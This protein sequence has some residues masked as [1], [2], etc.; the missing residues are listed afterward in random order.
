MSRRAGVAARR[1]VRAAGGVRLGRV[2]P[3]GRQ[4]PA[5]DDAAADDRPA[6]DG[7]ARRDAAADDDRAAAVTTTTTPLAD[8]PPCPV[9]ALDGVTAPVEITFWHAMTSENEKALIELTDA[10]NA[11]QPKVR[12][13]LE[14]QGG[15]KQTIDKYT[16]S[17]PGQ[18]AGHGDAAR[19]HGAADGRLGLGD[20]GRGVHRGQRASTRR[21][22]STGRCSR[23]QTEGVQWS[24][25][26]NVSEPVLFYNKTAFANAGLDPDDP[27]VSLEELR[28]TSQ[29]LVDAPG[30]GVGMAFDSGVDSG[31]GWFIE[32][33][34]ARAGEPYADNDNGRLGA[35]DAGAL[36]RAARRRP[37][38][39]GAVADHR[40]ARRHRR[41]QPERPGRAAQAG[42]PGSARRR[43]RSPRR[44]RSAPSRRCST[45]AS[46]R[47]S[48][49]SSS[50]SA[51]C[52]GPARCPSAIVGGASL[53]VVAEKGDDQ[54]AAVWDYMQFLTSAQSQSTWAAATG[55]VPVREDALD[56]RP[57][58]DDVRDRPPLQGRLRPARRPATTAR[59]RS[60][61]C[62]ARCS[63]CAPSP[64][65]PWPAI[66]G[67]ADVAST[68]AA[69]A[70]QSDALI[71]ELQRPQLTHH[72]G[73]NRSWAG[74]VPVCRDGSRPDQA[75]SEAAARC[76]RP[77]T[78]DGCGC[79]RRPGAGRRISWRYVKRT[80]DVA[81][82]GELG[83]AHPV[84][85]ELG[86]VAT[87]AVPAVALE[88]DR[89]ADEPEVDLVAR[90]GR[91][92][93]V[94]GG[95]P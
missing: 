68:L 91:R 84:A 93:T 79:A 69:A 83:V 4:R 7:G 8:L 86:P 46:S 44:R 5:A 21:R 85:L 25:P 26:F 47:A 38:D 50:A 59:R 72:L 71:A 49:A 76:G 22:S 39:G 78:D 40:R 60:G 9:D 66:F 35:G 51:R 94:A 1:G 92:G 87:V 37:A 19:V 56:A 81:G 77:A 65:A 41:R 31:G 30:E 24:M 15:Y 28:T 14:N 36:R 6:G 61:R 52:R 17:E 12:V 33:W 16:Q 29:A 64:P 3:R 70:Q 42:R 43:W 73:G 58:Q 67:G 90:T 10:Y 13:R 88:H 23:Y 95:S 75:A 63:R 27:P 20:P 48:R 34:F 11:S 2:D 53:Y 80:R 57:D 55:Y 54:A 32:Q 89:R 74:S 82:G 62:S 45:A 18:P